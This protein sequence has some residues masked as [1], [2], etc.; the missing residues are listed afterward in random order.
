MIHKPKLRTDSLAVHAGRGDF[1]SIPVHAPPIDLSSTYPLGDLDGA[2]SDFDAWAEGRAHAANPI[3]ARL[4]NPTVAR[5]EEAL[6]AM[7]GAE[8]AVAFASGMAAITACLLDARGRGRNVVGVRPL[9]GTTDHLLDSGMLGHVVRWAEPGSVREA[10]DGETALVILETPCNPT[11]QLVDIEGVVRQAGP[12]PVLVD[13]TFAT[14]ILQ[15]PLAHGAA[16]TLHSATKFLGGHGDVIAGIVACSEERARGLRQVRLM[17]GALLHPFA[18]F[19]LHRALPTLPVRVRAAQKSASILAARLEGHP[20]VERVLY[21]GTGA[22][23]P[24]G[25]VGRQMRGPGCIVSFVLRGGYEMASAVMRGVRLV[26]SA[27]SLGTT[28]TLVQHPM[29][30]THR[31]VDP[32]ARE[33]TGIVAGLLRVSVGLEDVEDLWSDLDRAI[34]EAERTV[35]RRTVVGV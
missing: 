6:A 30:L 3:Y 23:D 20:A 28:D 5:Y 24:E 35:E 31:V 32:S 34:A 8:A 12:V 16:Y 29:G 4:H 25:L 17:T 15:N 7:E 33:R 11:L 1:A 10:V 26:T 14:P 13:S 2:T 22:C 18:A 19:L 27:V 9:Y 21:P